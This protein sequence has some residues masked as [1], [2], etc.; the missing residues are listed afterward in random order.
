MTNHTNTRHHLTANPSDLDQELTVRTLLT[1]TT[2]NQLATTLGPDTAAADRACEICGQW[3]ANQTNGR[4]IHARCQAE[5]RAQLIANGCDAATR[6]LRWEYTAAYRRRLRLPGV[7]PNK[8][9]ADQTACQE[10]RHHVPVVLA[11]HL[12]GINLV[13]W[14]DPNPAVI[15][16]I[17]ELPGGWT[18]DI[19]WD[20][21]PTGPSATPPP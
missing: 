8:L 2:N 7:H 3:T 10:L 20:Y 1:A 17:W 21:H 18:I 16:S 9:D 11:R 13:E 4:R 19:G 5:Q 15:D 12:P 14:L 6:Q